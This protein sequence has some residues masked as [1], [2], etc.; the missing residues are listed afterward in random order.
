MQRFAPF[1]QRLRQIFATIFAIFAA[2]AAKYAAIAAKGQ[3]R[4]SAPTIC[5]DFGI[6]YGDCGKISPRFAE[7]TVCRDGCTGTPLMPGMLTPVTLPVRAA[8]TGTANRSQIRPF[9]YTNRK[10]ANFSTNF[11]FTPSANKI[12]TWVF[13]PEPCCPT[14]FPLPY[15][16]CCANLPTN[17]GSTWLYSSCS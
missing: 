11:R 14:T 4:R 5:G 3:T 13:S 9:P 12:S 6:F 8:Q 17:P 15:L 2:I 1:L 7:T 10:F 16:L